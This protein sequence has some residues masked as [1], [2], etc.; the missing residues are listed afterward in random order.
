MDLY[1]FMDDN[2]DIWDIYAESEREALHD[3]AL[4]TGRPASEF[5]FA[6]IGE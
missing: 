4:V 5:T 1:I 6:N 3:I 2:Y